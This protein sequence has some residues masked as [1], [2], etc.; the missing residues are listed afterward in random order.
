MTQDIDPTIMTI[1]KEI[2]TQYRD[3]L[4]IKMRDIF[5]C[6]LGEAAVTEMTKTVWVN[7][8]NKMNINQLHSLFRLHFILE[9]NNFCSQNCEFDNVTPAELIASKFLSLIGRS[10]G[11][12]E[13]KK[14]IRERNMTIETIP[15]M[16]HE[17]VYDDRMIQITQMTG[18][19]YNTSKEDRRKK[20]SEKPRYDKYQR[21]SEYQRIRSI[22]STN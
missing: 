16:I 19:I 10:T 1:D 15:D 9:R 18:E 2:L 13:Q 12:S 21:R 11:D 14:K 3:E 6:A 17:Y 22:L 4:E 7:D 8:P 20:W 5:I